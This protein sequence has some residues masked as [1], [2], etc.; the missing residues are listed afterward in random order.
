MTD[1]IMPGNPSPPPLLGIS[2]RETLSVTTPD[3][4]SE[5]TQETRVEADMQA[6]SYPS[7]VT[8]SSNSVCGP[9]A[10]E[11]L[12]RDGD[13]DV[14]VLRGIWRERVTQNYRRRTGSKARF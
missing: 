13:S 12:M 2:R 8:P 4:L 3:C 10:N 9:L 7:T 11:G 5:V 1:S 14:P 6:D